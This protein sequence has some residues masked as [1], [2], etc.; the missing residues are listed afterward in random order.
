MT[1]NSKQIQ[2]LKYEQA[3]TKER[4]SKYKKRVKF[5]LFFL[6]IPFA[7]YIFICLDHAYQNFGSVTTFLVITLSIL[8]ILT[9]VYL[10]A[11]KYKI[12][13]REREIKVIRSKLYQLMKLNDE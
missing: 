6:V 11:V 7:I 3:K 13:Q 12:K 9:L 8:V 4:I 2:K 5:H 10:M 1:G